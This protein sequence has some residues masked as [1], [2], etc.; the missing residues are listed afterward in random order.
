MAAAASTASSRLLHPSIPFYVVAGF[1]AN[2]LFLHQNLLEFAHLGAIF[3]VFVLGLR[4]EPSRLSSV[5]KDGLGASVSLA[6]VCGI[7]GFTA[8]AQV[9]NTLN[10]VYIGFASALS[11]SIIGLDMVE[12]DLDIDLLHGRLAESVQLFQDVI[13][14]MG[15]IAITGI[16]SPQPLVAAAQGIG[17]L[18]VAAFIR[19]HVIG[20]VA[21]TMEQSRE[22]TLLTT[23]GVLSLF[24]GASEIANLPTAVGAFAAGFSMAK[25]PYNEESLETV[26]PLKDFFSAVF[27]VSLGSMISVPGYAAIIAAGTVLGLAI[28]LRPVLTAA[29]LLEQGYDHRT[30]Y[31]TGFSLDQVSELA[32]V[33]SI[34]TFVSGTMSQPVFEGIVLAAV[35]SMTISSYSTR[36]RER[37][38]EAMK[39]LGIDEKRSLEPV[40]AEG[41]TLLAGY[42]QQG[43]MIAEE[44]DEIVL[45]ENDPEKVTEARQNGI[46]TVFGDALEKETW[47]AANAEKASAVISTVP[48]RKVSERAIEHSRAER[49]FL[50][51]GDIAEAKE[52]MDRGAA[53]AEV[54]EITAARRLSHHIRRSMEDENY[55]EELRR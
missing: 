52:F 18:T 26:S 51:A 10:A 11:S 55:P 40:D 43:R 28:V 44:L 33:L 30:S 32:L 22:L 47:R 38:V 6:S 15:I 31:L 3:L 41:H 17:I 27:F 53:F 39:M 34:Q 20:I 50:R 24:I 14:I 54:S 25:F 36:H 13:A 45:I 9:F 35:A 23:I 46:K 29:I 42:A 19:S 37:I 12:R 2:S 7:I 8:S 48:D 16:S 5:A 49:T 4:L 1:L 21:E